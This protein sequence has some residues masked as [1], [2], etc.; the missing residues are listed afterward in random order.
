M[1][2]YPCAYYALRHLIHITP[3]HKCSDKCIE[4]KVMRKLSNVLPWIHY[5]PRIQPNCTCD[6][7]FWNGNKKSQREGEGGRYMKPETYK[8]KLYTLQRAKQL[9]LVSHLASEHRKNAF[10]T[11][12]CLYEADSRHRFFSPFSVLVLSFCRSLISLRVTS[13][14]AIVRMM[15]VKDR[16]FYLVVIGWILVQ[17]RSALLELTRVKITSFQ[18]WDS[19]LP[20]SW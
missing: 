6:L 13:D 19:K 18:S 4:N 15:K 20:E 11:V 3:I 10:E 2:P 14:L 5:I 9:I 1:L 17:R 12:S 8:G 16:S 7:F